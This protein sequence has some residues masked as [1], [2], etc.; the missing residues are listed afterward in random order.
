MY[1]YIRLNLISM[2]I[3]LVLYYANYILYNAQN[4]LCEGK[5]FDEGVIDMSA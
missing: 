4:Y 5:E 1:I 3:K 2:T